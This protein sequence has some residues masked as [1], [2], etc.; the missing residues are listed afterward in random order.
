MLKLVQFRLPKL[1]GAPVDAL[2]KKKSNPY[3][4]LHY[5]CIQPD[6]TVLDFSTLSKLDPFFKMKF[7]TMQLIRS[8]EIESIPR[9]K[10]LLK[11]QAF[12]NLTDKV[13]WKMDQIQLEP[14]LYPR[15][16]IVCIGKNYLEHISEVQRAD[17]TLNVTGVNS[18]ELSADAVVKQVTQYPVFFTKS[19]SAL[20]G[21]GKLIQNHKNL[22]NFLDY[23]AELAVVIGKKATNVLAKD[24]MQY[25]F[26][27]M[28]ANDI[29]AR[30]IQKRHN[31]WYKGKSLNTSCP[32]GPYLVP[33]CDI[34]PSDLSIKLWLNDELKQNSRT[35][36]M[37]HKIPD[38]IQSLTEGATLEAG[39]V[40]LTGT[41]EGVGFAANPPRTLQP[42]DRV[43][44]EIEGLGILENTVEN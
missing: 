34:D 8:K 19:S 41:P 18:S 39:D 25:V 15:R 32:I 12:A 21:P 5:G 28:C 17:T 3:P 13:I 29:T 42:N 23:E 11:S 36:R 4:V 37:I 30:D 31:Q 26:G 43:R 27:Y 35:S 22:T 20:T 14:P 24:A 2:T 10:A 33:A 16:N 7:S 40:I 9:L 44:I 38:I 6:G 1:A